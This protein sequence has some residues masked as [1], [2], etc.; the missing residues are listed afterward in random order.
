MFLYGAGVDIPAFKHWYFRTEFRGLAYKAPDF[1][2][3]PLRTN[4]FSFT[5]EPS[6]GVAYRF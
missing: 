2:L 4:A 6:L 3:S 1:K 5:Y